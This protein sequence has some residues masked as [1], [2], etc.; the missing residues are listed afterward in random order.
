MQNVNNRRK[1]QT[2]TTEFINADAKKDITINVKSFFSKHWKAPKD[3]KTNFVSPFFP[4]LCNC[5]ASYTL[6]L[7]HSLM[8]QAKICITS[9]LT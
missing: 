4:Q 8:L 5:R 2:I 3:C 7:S 1:Q 9:S 6:V